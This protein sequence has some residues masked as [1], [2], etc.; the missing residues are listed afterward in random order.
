MTSAPTV[1]NVLPDL[2]AQLIEVLRRD[3]RGDLADQIV[4]LPFGQ[5]CAC[6]DDFCSSFYKGPKPSS[7]WASEGKHANVCL[8]CPS[9]DHGMVVLDVVK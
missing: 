2:A 5:R 4:A 6:G 3:G 9:V 8:V 7:S 1:G